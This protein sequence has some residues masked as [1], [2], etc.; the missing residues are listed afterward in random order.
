MFG[1]QREGGFKAGETE[2]CEKEHAD[3]QAEFGLREGVAPLR[4]LGSRRD[5]RGTGLAALAEDEPAQDKITRTETGG[6]PAR[7]LPAK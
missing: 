2:R 3:E 1:Q 7:S 6:N 5:G 4:E